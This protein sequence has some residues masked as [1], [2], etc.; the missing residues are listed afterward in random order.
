MSW[1]ESQCGWKWVG[2]ASDKTLQQ[3]KDATR[4]QA[5]HAVSQAVWGRKRGKTVWKGLALVTSKRPLSGYNGKEQQCSQQGLQRCCRKGD[6]L[7]VFP[8]GFP[9]PW[10]AGVRGGGEAEA[11]LCGPAGC[12]PLASKP[13]WSLVLAAH[14]VSH[15]TALFWFW[16][17]AEVH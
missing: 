2:F 3:E 13:S 11:G 16:V 17:A 10:A 15:V 12:P 14:R 4:P 6:G 5:K 9:F 1:N 8:A 7:D